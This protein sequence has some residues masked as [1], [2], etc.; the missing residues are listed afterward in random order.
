MVFELKP[1][2]HLVPILEGLSLRQQGRSLSVAKR[3]DRLLQLKS[4]H[5]ALGSS[6]RE[7][8]KGRLDIGVTRGMGM[9]PVF[10]YPLL[11]GQRKLNGHSTIGESPICGKHPIGELWDM[12]QVV[13]KLN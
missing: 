2:E 13:S 7:G 12:W 5:F 11:G 1:Q 9:S 3:R 4:D 10:W 6:S 8:Y